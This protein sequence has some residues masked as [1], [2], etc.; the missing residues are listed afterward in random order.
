MTGPTNPEADA[1]FQDAERLFQQG[2]LVEAEAR[3]RPARQ[4]PQGDPLG[5]EGAV[6]P[7]RD[8]V[9]ARQVRGR[10]RQLRDAS[11]PTIPAPSYLDKLVDREY[12]IAQTWLAERRPQGQARAEAPL[13]RPIQRPDAPR[14]TPTATPSSALEHVRHHDPTGP[15]SDDAVLRDRRRAHGEPG[16]TSWPPCY[17]DQLI[18]DHPKSPF[19]Q[20]CPARQHRRA[21]EGLHRPRV[22]RRPAWRRPA[23][24][25]K[26][27]MATF[28]ERPD[29]QREALSHPRPDQRPGGRTDL[30]R[31]ATTTSGSA[32]SPRP[33]S[34]S[35]RSDTRWPK[36]E[37]AAKA[38]TDLASLAKMPRK[39]SLP[40]KIM[41]APGSVDPFS[42][43]AGGGNGATGGMPGMGMMGGPGGMN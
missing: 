43:G 31:S 13:V 11:S 7:G 40:S 16:I 25:I 28:P 15:L 37:W 9:P 30:S 12:A 27:T 3:L 5:R 6:L 10:P 2:K 20:R 1:E 21:D 22:R 36:S 38:K 4:E 35:A 8:P 39:E 41:T 42:S 33:S 18:T 14:S 24:M 23:S 19:L 29:E 17:Y 32:R 34:T 26:Q